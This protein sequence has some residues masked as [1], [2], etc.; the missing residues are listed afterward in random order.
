MVGRIRDPLTGSIRSAGSRKESRKNEDRDANPLND[1]IGSEVVRRSDRAKY[2]KQGPSTKALAETDLQAV[3]SKGSGTREKWLKKALQQVQD[4]ELPAVEV[5][6]IL[7]VPDFSADLKDKTG[8]SIYRL[9][10]SKLSLFSKGQQRFLAKECP[11]AQ[12]FSG[13]GGGQAAGSESTPKAG[14][15]AAEAMMERVREFVRQ[16]QGLELDQA[17]AQP[18]AQ[19]APQP[20]PSAESAFP[21]P[22]MPGSAPIT[23]QSVGVKPPRQDMSAVANILA[24]A[25]SA[26]LKSEAVA[27]VAK[28]APPAQPEAPQAEDKREE[29][30]NAKQRAASSSSSRPR[31]RQTKRR[32]SPSSSRSRSPSRTQRGKGLRSDSRDGRRR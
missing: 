22:G 24:R 8:R 1:N 20:V 12:M 31:G 16:Q 18:V 14:E 21:M 19:A 13:E 17:A 9:I 11:L 32:R 30:S 26:A 23:A 27:S 7:K 5:Y 10:M 25:S 29:R 28:T 2:V 3:L 6:N 4:G 15:E